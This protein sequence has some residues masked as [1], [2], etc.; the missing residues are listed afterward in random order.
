MDWFKG[1][2]HGKNGGFDGNIYGK[3]MI[4][5]DLFGYFGIH[6]EPLGFDDPYANQVLVYL[7]TKLDVFVRAN[8]GVHIPAPWF[9]YGIALAVRYSH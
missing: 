3:M 8:V 6:D 1:I 2:N 4:Y 5:W 7:P 9:A